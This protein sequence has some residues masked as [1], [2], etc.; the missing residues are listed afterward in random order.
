MSSCHN[1]QPQ[2]ICANDIRYTLNQIKAI[3]E[4]ETLK[5]ASDRVKEVD[6]REVYRRRI[7]TRAE[8]VEIY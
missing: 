7:K 1:S 2:A 6:S 4:T 8:K 3:L 5:T